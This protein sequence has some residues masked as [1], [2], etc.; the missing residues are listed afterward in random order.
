MEEKKLFS[1][2]QDEMKERRWTVKEAAEALNVSEATFYNWQRGQLSK[3]G[4]L[5]IRVFLRSIGAVHDTGDVKITAPNNSGTV[6]GKNVGNGAPVDFSAAIRKIMASDRL[7]DAEK[8]K[9][10]DVLNN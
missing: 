1:M 10:I 5:A 2:F 7:T 8:L 4:R 3:R 9:V 6:I